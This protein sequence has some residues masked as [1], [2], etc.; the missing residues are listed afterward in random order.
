MP[1][2]VSRVLRLWQV[3]PHILP[4]GKFVLVDDDGHMKTCTGWLPCHHGNVQYELRFKA[5]GD[6]ADVL[7]MNMLR[8]K[9]RAPVSVAGKLIDKGKLAPVGYTKEEYLKQAEHAYRDQATWTV[10]VTY[11]YWR[12]YDTN[13]REV[14]KALTNDPEAICTRHSPACIESL[15]YSPERALVAIN[16][17]LQTLA[18][19]P[20][21]DLE[22][23]KVRMQWQ[24]DTRYS[25]ATL[26]QPSEHVRDVQHYQ[27]MW[28]TFNEIEHVKMIK[29]AFADNIELWL[30]TP[31]QTAIGERCV[32][33]ATLEEAF[34]LKCFVKTDIYMLE[35]PFK[36]DERQEMG[37]PDIRL[38]PTGAS[39]AIPWAH[40]WGIEQWL[41][42]AKRQP[43]SLMCIGRLDQYARGRGQIFR[44][45]LDASYPCQIGHHFKMNRVEMVTTEDVAGFVHS[46]N[47]PTI[48]CFSDEP[49]PGIDTERRWIPRPR[50]IRTLAN[51]TWAG[52]QPPRVALQEEP[53]TLKVGDNASVVNVRSI[54]TPV[55]VAVYICQSNTKP[56][57]IHVARTLCR[58]KLYVVNC[59]FPPFMW[60]PKV[61]ARIAISPF[62]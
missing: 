16:R 5:N 4:P 27:K 7:A 26:K 24:L 61:G 38:L 25:T 35:L 9:K 17:M 29:D 52:V 15:M 60:E 10:A 43:E 56:L 39:V 34:A 57:D 14:F 13:I 33:V 36:D 47:Y 41:A 22:G 62:I 28:T 1:W 59:R 53:F 44:Q 20:Y 8:K 19:P 46:L 21:D 31:C 42:L 40:W 12:V 45:M 58:H 54:L 30:G 32:V 11:P 55:D 2:Q 23:F 51:R 6:I 48:Q 50:R 37:L 3:Y 49:V 18:E